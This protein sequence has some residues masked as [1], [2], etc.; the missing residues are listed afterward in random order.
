LALKGK[1]IEGFPTL[2]EIRDR[3]K[4]YGIKA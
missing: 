3:A 4:I 2:E 1:R